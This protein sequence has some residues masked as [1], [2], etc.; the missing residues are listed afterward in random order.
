MRSGASRSTDGAAAAASR[1]CS[2]GLGEERA[3]S[4]AASASA[5]PGSTR[6]PFSPSCDDLGHA[7]RRGGDHRRADRQRLDERVREVLPGRR[8]HSCVGGAKELEHASRGCAPRNRT[9]PVEPQRL[10]SRLE[11][12]RSGPSPA[13]T[14]DDAVATARPLRARSRAPSALS[15]RPAKASSR[16]VDAELAPQPRR[17]GAARVPPAPGSAGPM[18]RSGAMPQPR[19]SSRR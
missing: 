10:G 11:R 3:R 4:P 2:S 15:S 12:A 16:A 19:A 17:G 13:S 1:C 9:R 8:E 18:T 6:S 5:S 14:S 7:A